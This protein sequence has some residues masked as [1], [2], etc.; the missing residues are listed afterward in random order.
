MEKALEKAR[1]GY[2][3]CRL[4]EENGDIE[5]RKRSDLPEL[6]S[7]FDF[8]LELK[9]SLDEELGEEDEEFE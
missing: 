7:R 5:F 3:F 4:G 9:K 2:V 6:M 8:I 1:D